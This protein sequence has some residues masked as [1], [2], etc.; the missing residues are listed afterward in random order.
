MLVMNG[1]GPSSSCL[2]SPSFNADSTCSFILR[3]SI[4]EKVVKAMVLLRFLICVLII[5]IYLVPLCDTPLV[6]WIRAA[7]PPPPTTDPPTTD[8]ASTMAPPSAGP[9]SAGHNGG[10]P[11][12]GM[13]D[14]SPK[15]SS[16]PE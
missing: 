6:D 4:A 16:R 13:E 3:L 7:R 5:M 2:L 9:P 11:E 10:S 1:A 8:T 12:A 15:P 14:E